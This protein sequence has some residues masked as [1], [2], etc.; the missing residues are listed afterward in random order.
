M[1]IFPWSKSK[2]RINLLNLFAFTLLDVQDL[3][4][5]F[6]NTVD[7]PSEPD[8][9]PNVFARALPRIVLESHPAYSKDDRLSDILSGEIHLENVYIC[10]ILRASSS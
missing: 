3:N 6:I 8:P 5:D 9:H 10:I 7:S 1:K 2:F 4:P